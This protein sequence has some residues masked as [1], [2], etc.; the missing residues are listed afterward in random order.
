MHTCTL[1]EPMES[2]KVYGNVV[3]KIY[4]LYKTINLCLALS[5]LLAFLLWNLSSSLLPESLEE[6]DVEL[7]PW[8]ALRRLQ[9]GKSD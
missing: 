4:K 6:D 2:P 5:M 7:D 3:F 8:N 1:S 9:Y